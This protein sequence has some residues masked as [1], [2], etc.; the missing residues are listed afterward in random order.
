MKTDN[1]KMSEAIN[2]I[3]LSVLLRFCKAT[4][5]TEKYLLWGKYQI[6]YTSVYVCIWII[7]MWESTEHFVS[8]FHNL[9]HSSCPWILQLSYLSQLA[10]DPVLDSALFIATGNYVKKEEERG[11][12]ILWE[13]SSLWFINFFFL[14]GVDWKLAIL[15]MANLTSV[16]QAAFP[17]I[18]ISLFTP[19]SREYVSTVAC[20]QYY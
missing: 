5:I 12:R 13:L 9:P 15:H 16:L 20:Q 1:G 7:Y 2:D 19:Y 4:E 11:C 10:D 3:L 14:L 8:C 6:T 18:Y 17:K